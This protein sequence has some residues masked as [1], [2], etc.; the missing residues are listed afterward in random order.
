VP[1]GKADARVIIDGDEQ[2]LKACAPGMVARVAGDAVSDRLDP[3]QG[4][5]VQMQEIA[6]CCVFVAH[7]RNG[8]V[9]GRKPGQAGRARTRLTVALD[10]PS[11]CAMR[12]I[13]RRFLR[14]STIVSAVRGAIAR[15]LLIGREERSINPASPKDKYR[16]THLRTV[17]ALTAKRAATALTSCFA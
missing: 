6:G 2:A 15:G 5:D 12:A 9:E 10:I 1:P 8:R 11:A 16:P 14:N 3:A 4:L 17:A 7:H 13:V